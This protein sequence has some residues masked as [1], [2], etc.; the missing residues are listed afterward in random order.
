MPKK[1]LSTTTINK[2]NNFK[3]AT[4]INTSINS[5]NDSLTSETNILEKQFNSFYSIL[6]EKIK[7]RKYRLVVNQ[8]IQSREDYK[9]VPNFYKLSF[10]KI[11]AIYK[12]IK[13]KLNKYELIIQK[14]SHS[15]NAKKYSRR[16]S[17][18]NQ[19]NAVKN[20]VHQLTIIDKYYSDV[21]KEL[22]YLINLYQHNNVFI[23]DII[24]ECYIKFLLIKVYHCEKINR[25]VNGFVYLCLAHNLIDKYISFL[26]TPNAIVECVKVYLHLTRYLIINYNFIEAQKYIEK[27]IALSNKEILFRTNFS[28]Q[29]EV[30]TVKMN[31][32]FLYLSIAYL[33]YGLIEEYLGYINVAIDAYAL[34]KFLSEKFVIDKYFLFKKYVSMIYNR[35]I[36][37]KEAIKYFGEQ[38]DWYESEKR[39][40]HLLEKEKQVLYEKSKKEKFDSIKNKETEL[41]LENLKIPQ[42]EGIDKN[43]VGET[44]KQRRKKY[45]Y[46]TKMTSSLKVIHAYMSEESKEIINNMNQIKIADLDYNAQ[47][48]VAKILTKLH[49]K[50]KQENKRYHRRFSYSQQNIPEI[51]EKAK[52]RNSQLSN[53]H[54]SSTYKIHSNSSD[55]NV[56]NINLCQNKNNSLNFL[57]SNN[58]LS[59]PLS[60]CSLIKSPSTNHS[61]IQN[62]SNN[63]DK[64]IMFNYKTNN[65]NLTTK[66]KPFVRLSKSNFNNKKEIIKYSNST[67]NTPLINYT[68]SSNIKANENSKR[69]LSLSLAKRHK[70]PRYFV[71]KK[72]FEY[73]HSFKA[74]KLHLDKISTKEINFH[75]NIL[76]MKRNEPKL[77]EDILNEENYEICAERDFKVLRNLINLNP[78]NEKHKLMNLTFHE[79]RELRKKESLQNSLLMSLST[80][81]MNEFQKLQRKAN[82]KY[83][84]DSIYNFHNFDEKSKIYE[85]NQACNL[86]NNEFLNDL[87]KQIR[88]L[89]DRQK[90]DKK[91]ESFIRKNNP[92]KNRLLSN[93]FKEYVSFNQEDGVKEKD[94]FKDVEKK[95]KNF[96]LDTF[97]KFTKNKKERERINSFSEK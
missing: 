18:I 55:K 30:N 24:V 51:E 77:V 68:N 28:D 4:S 36:L 37:Y 12:I 11:K 2:Y 58:S 14:N 26:K 94:W 79:V 84:N 17:N 89:K 40:I 82:L 83:N 92:I 6:K 53:S 10:L 74:K 75:K 20:T 50:E 42:I 29:I 76:R 88:L 60:P 65:I 43:I 73:S 78:D 57:N 66:Q 96:N 93:G 15:E 34:S 95:E 61:T 67:R 85:N 9:E 46:S 1:K 21:Q 80:K 97:L 52:P 16:L 32:T 63:I 38:Q 45:N 91:K 71:S 48:N 86:K 81:S 70:I 25:Y 41:K 49:N 72:S 7:Q 13:H 22:N 27:C 33:Y 35:S 44:I 62:N 31:K 3:N 39:R 54:N 5:S 64:R 90:E 69:F 59:Q 56:S 19:I 87:N 23:L 8:I 47:Q